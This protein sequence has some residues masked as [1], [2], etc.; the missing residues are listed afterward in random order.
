MVWL[1]ADST[2]SRKN[3]AINIAIELMLGLDP[4]SINLIEGKHSQ[5]SLFDAL[6]RGADDM[7]EPRNA[8]G[9]IVADE[10]GM[11]LTKESF[12]ESLATDITALNTARDG[13]ARRRM[14]NLDV[15][16]WNVCLGMLA[17][18][19]PTGLAHEIPR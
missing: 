18:T 1:V 4:D 8:I 7:G 17:G 11:F 16:L 14:R 15:Q 9:I 19:T 2:V 12:A 6:N 10:L 13:W 3:T 5:A